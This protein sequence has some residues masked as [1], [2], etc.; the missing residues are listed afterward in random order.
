M[1]PTRTPL[2]WLNLTHDLRRLIVSMA[3]IMFAVILMFMQIGF[4]NA[5]LDGSVEIL[6]QLDTDLVILSKSKY[7]LTVSA[8]F[9]RRRL[10]QALGVPGIKSAYP[11]YIEMHQSLWK[12]VDEPTPPRHIRVIAFDPAQPVLLLPEVNAQTDELQ[13]PDTALIDEKSK[14]DYGVS[15]AGLERELAGRSIHVVGTFRLGTDFVNDANVVISAD[16]FAKFF[17][18]GG[19]AEE[20]LGLVEIGL[21]KAEAGTDPPSL[22]SALIEA[23]PDDVVVRTKDEY[24]EEERDFWLKH[25]PIGFIFGLGTAIGFIVGMVICYQILSADVADHWSEFATLKAIGYSNRYLDRV[26]LTEAVWLALLGFLPGLLATQLLYSMMVLQTG[27]PMRLTTMRVG[28]VL[29]LTVLMCVS[30]GSLALRKVRAADPAEV[31]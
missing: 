20:T 2:A 22:K 13:L 27:L 14:R 6:R 17:P 25:A 3:G 16:N 18:H 11:I 5:L 9:P 12:N 8:P 21:I 31:F 15:R 28:F 23:L 29:F 1:L 24:V 10:Y 26:V 30:S 4:L 7:C 19:S